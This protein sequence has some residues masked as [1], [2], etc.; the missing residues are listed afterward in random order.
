MPP[1]SLIERTLAWWHVDLK[2]SS[3]RP[4]A[5]RIV[6]V[7]ILAA[8]GSVGVNALLVALVTYLNPPLTSYAHFQLDDYGT[9]TVIGVLAASAAWDVVLRISSSPRWLLLRMAVLVTVVLW[10]PDVYLFT[11]H[12][13]SAGVVTL[14]IMHLAVAL[15]TY[16]ALVR[17]A[18]PSSKPE[19]PHT[20]LPDEASAFLLSQLSTAPEEPGETLRRSYFI[21]MMVGVIAE[22]IIGGVELFYVPLNRPTGWLAHHGEPIYVVHALL[23]MALGVG[24]LYV[25]SRALTT[26]HL[27]QVDRTAAVGGFLGVAT[28]AIGGAMSYEQS[29]RVYA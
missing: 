6:I 5:I 11:K 9:L 10:I 15:V 4:S 18:A 22:L 26:A 8:L 19:I 16:N 25:V 1:S 24:A 29:L 12:E 27:V 21:A 20:S 13:P 7:A 17:F 14:M 23:G 28:G 2:P 3:E